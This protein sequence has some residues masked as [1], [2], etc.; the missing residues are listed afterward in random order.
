MDKIFKPCSTHFVEPPHPQISMFQRTCSQKWCWGGDFF[1]PLG[2][3]HLRLHSHWTLG[4]RGLYRIERVWIFRPST[5]F[6]HILSCIPTIT[7]VPWFSHLEFSYKLLRYMRF[8]LH[9]FHTIGRVSATQLGQV[10]FPGCL[11]LQPGHTPGI[12]H[13]IDENH[14]IRWSHCPK[15]TCQQSWRPNQ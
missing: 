2:L 15:S 1:R 5:V 11:M 8:F 10:S 4:A 7:D 14:L 12:E 6:I 3:T 13:H 9:N